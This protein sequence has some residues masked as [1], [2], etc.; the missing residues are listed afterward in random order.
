MNINLT[1]EDIKKL[2]D[3]EPRNVHH[4]M[5]DSEWVGLNFV[6]KDNDEK[7]YYLFDL[8]NHSLRTDHLTAERMAEHLGETLLNHHDYAYLLV[9]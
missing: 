8:H 2:C 1:G 4:V 3:S 7:M 6:V 9:N 5:L